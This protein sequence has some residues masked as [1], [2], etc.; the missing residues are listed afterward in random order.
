MER[1]AMNLITIST[2]ATDALIGTTILGLAAIGLSLALKKFSAATRHYYWL[3]IITCLLLLPALSSISPKYRVNVPTQA[4]AVQPEIEAETASHFQHSL[5]AEESPQ[6][7]I[8]PI[9]SSLE[10][11]LNDS[12]EGKPMAS[13][14]SPSSFDLR[15][16]LLF[17]WA[18]GSAFIVLWITAGW[19]RIRRL[20][21]QSTSIKEGSLITQCATISR[22]MM[23]SRRFN[24]LI[25]K[26]TLMPMVVGTKKATLILP[27][28]FEDWDST[29]QAAVLAHEIGHIQRY[30]CSTQ[31]LG[32]LLCALYWFHPISW[33]IT[34]KL[35]AE[36]EAACDDLAIRSGTCPSQYA[37][38]LLTIARSLKGLRILTG[39]T[40]QIAGYSKL[41][42]RL[43]RILNR[44]INRNRLTRMSVLICTAAT[45]TSAL[46][47]STIRI[48]AKNRENIA[49]T[50]ATEPRVVEVKA[51]PSTE[52]K[53]SL[54]VDELNKLAWLAAQETAIETEQA[55]QRKEHRDE[56]ETA[57]TRIPP[58]A[59]NSN[60]EHLATFQPDNET[61]EA[62]LKFAGKIA[63]VKTITISSQLDRPATVLWRAAPG[64]RVEKGD[65][66]LEFETSLLIDELEANKI[67]LAREEGKIN[68]VN[69][70]LA[71]IERNKALEIETGNL[72]LHLTEMQQKKGQADFNLRL[73]QTG[74]DLKIAIKRL[75]KAEAALEE[76]QAQYKEGVVGA[77]K[78]RTASIAVEEAKYKIE[79]ASD[80]R[81]NLLNHDRIYEDAEQKLSIQQAKS[82][83]QKN[84]T[85][86]ENQI[87]TAEEELSALLTIQLIKELRVKRIEQRI[88]G[89][90]VLA[91]FT[92]IITNVQSPEASGRLISKPPLSI[93]AGSIVRK[94]QP[95]MNIHDTENLILRFSVRNKSAPRINLGQRARIIVDAAPELE[96]TGK[97]VEISKPVIFYHFNDR[98]EHIR[99]VTVSPDP[100]GRD[101]LHVGLSYR[102]ELIQ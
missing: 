99:W 49:P 14:P 83:H 35:Q 85:Q 80:T 8:I 51:L 43:R 16:P 53:I 100:K 70:L 41:E 23:G 94:R 74:N 56:D 98:A 48:S 57:E 86:L 92:G 69:S 36:A 21:S 19:L 13:N 81:E 42:N 79:L 82:A 32:Q 61:S 84:L 60:P 102:V 44:R 2:L 78:V 3:M 95:I 65:L 67:E 72:N 54:T 96:L 33:I 76:S 34:R 27:A 97:V 10:A 29:K 24:V 47:F 71:D 46:L 66:I 62:P 52:P 88:Q 73:K 40:A 68:T 93:T 37:E 90:R 17:T 4:M 89:S 6:I 91:P 45:L 58:V 31:L 59:F 77:D 9:N 15:Q 18:I 38:H 50:P 28:G 26:S 20:I 75:E 7:G 11:P 87:A 39:T 22:Q 5:G 30:D 1:F 12:T 63:S 55:K 64:D 101:I 25:S